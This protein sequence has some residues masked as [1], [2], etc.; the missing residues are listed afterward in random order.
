MDQYQKQTLI[1]QVTKMPYCYQRDDLLCLLNNPP[2]ANEM[3][4][5]V[6][7]GPVNSGKS[8]LLNALITRKHFA[9]ADRRMTVAIEEYEY[10]GVIYRD[11]P[12]WDSNTV[13]DERVALE[14]LKNADVWIYN[15]SAPQGELSQMDLRC[16]S[17]FTNEVASYP[18]CK[19]V[20][21]ISISK[22]EEVGDNITAISQSIQQQ[23]KTL[24]FREG[25]GLPFVKLVTVS[26][27][28]SFRAEVAQNPIERDHFLKA[29][30]LPQLRSAIK[31]TLKSRGEKHDLHYHA[32]VRESLETLKSYY[33]QQSQMLQSEHQ[34]KQSELSEMRS[35]SS[36]VIDHY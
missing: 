10:D 35:S 23:L 4:C 32:Q 15:H 6:I 2:S 13:E 36:Y 34:R 26:A 28:R 31:S 17:A 11:T 24:S 12:G 29:S 9:V 3:P 5:V 8:S 1:T 27:S 25:Q 30:G 7:F 18:E 21:L 22:V 14:G 33:K 20:L 19:K 16:L